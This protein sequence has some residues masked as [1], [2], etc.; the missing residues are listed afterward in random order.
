MVRMMEIAT[1]VRK[2]YE[3]ISES[4]YGPSNLCGYCCRAA[5]QLFLAA[6][7]HGINGVQ[8]V[9][10]SGHVYNIYNGHIVDVTAT[11]F[12]V[13]DPIYVVPVGEASLH[14]AWKMVR[15][16]YNSIDKFAKETGWLPN[17]K[18]DFSIVLK[19]DTFDVFQEYPYCD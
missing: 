15:G 9:L 10:G 11:Q 5:A 8:M 17:I 1:Q 14:G 16:P 6:Q 7:R 4:E 12:G 13:G 18:R 3:E 19:Y 2:A